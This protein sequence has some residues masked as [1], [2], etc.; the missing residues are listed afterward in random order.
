[1]H[2]HMACARN[3]DLSLSLLLSL[4]PLPL[5]FCF[6]PVCNGPNHRIIQMITVFCVIQPQ[7]ALLFLNCFTNELHNGL[8]NMESLAE[9]ILKC[10]SIYIYIYFW[11][12]FLQ[13]KIKQTHARKKNIS[14]SRQLMLLRLYDHE[15]SYDDYNVSSFF[16]DSRDVKGDRGS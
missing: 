12:F 8:A 15:C 7:A 11:S 16:S 9:A 6:L 10:I 13:K 1:M 2:K 5:L 14:I 4:S 3:Y